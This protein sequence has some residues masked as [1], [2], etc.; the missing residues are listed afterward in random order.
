MHKILAPQISV[1]SI[2][3]YYRPGQVTFTAVDNV[4]LD[5]TQGEFLAITGRS[6]VGKSTLLS[7]IGG[8]VRPSSGMICVDGIDLNSLGDPALS[9]LRAQKIGFV[10]QFASLLPTLTVLENVQLPS[11]FANRS[12]NAK[13]AL[14]LLQMVGLSDKARNYPSQLSGGQQRRVAVAR[15][16]MN[17]PAVLLADEPTGDLD[18]ATEADVL[19]LFRSLNTQGM[20]ILLVTHN[21]E[22]ASYGN[23]NFRM[24][25]GRLFEVKLPKPR[26]EL[27]RWEP[28][29]VLATSYC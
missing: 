18:V 22:L 19:E 5:V 6:G 20:T 13:R 23:R 7:L 27:K 26:K 17:Q 1:R 25:Q 12:T 4:S 10:F 21:P 11:L 15:A 9:A 2:S 24:E 28:G 3:K 29:A 8:L 16:L 14:D